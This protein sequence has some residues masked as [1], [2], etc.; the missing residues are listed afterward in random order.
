MISEEEAPPLLDSEEEPDNEPSPF[1]HLGEDRPRLCQQRVPLESNGNLTSMHTLYDW[2]SPNTL[3]RIDS[4]RGIGLQGVRALRQAIKGYQGMGTITDSGAGNKG[5][6][7]V[8]VTPFCV[9]R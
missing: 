3:V 1:A 7:R 5:P 6:S 9:V 4:A 2:E 8:D